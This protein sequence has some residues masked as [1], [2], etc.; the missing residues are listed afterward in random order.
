MSKNC[1]QINRN[2]LFRTPRFI[3]FGLPSSY[4]IPQ[5]PPAPD[6]CSSR[7]RSSASAWETVL[8]LSGS[9]WR[10]LS[11]FEEFSEIWL[12]SSCFD[13]VFWLLWRS[14][15]PRQCTLAWGGLLGGTDQPWASNALNKVVDKYR[16]PGTCNWL[17]NVLFRMDGGPKIFTFMLWYFSSLLYVYWGI[18]EVKEHAF[19]LS[20]WR[21]SR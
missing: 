1:F 11:W 13:S 21:N 8:A 9:V 5:A 14:I 7:S 20:D 17:D 16:A 2:M 12:A 10:L 6:N 18:C 19:N 15:I 4:S 3:A